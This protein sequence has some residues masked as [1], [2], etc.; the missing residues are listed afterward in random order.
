MYS[1]PI[2]LTGILGI[3]LFAV[4]WRALPA[5]APQGTSVL[6]ILE[7]PKALVLPVLCLGL[8]SIAAFSRYMRSSTIENLVQDYVRLARAKGAGPA[9]IMYRHVAR[10]AL[11]PVTTQ[12]GLFL[13]ILFAGT[14]ITEAVFNYP[15]MGLLFWTAAGARDYPTELG[16]VLVVGVATVV[17]SLLADI[18]YG[19]LD[20]R[21]R[22]ASRASQ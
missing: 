3:W 2:F 17:G 19:V 21:I 1:A 15:G 6:Q 13:P 8:G 16:V 7:D 5:Q 12:V 11:G 22:E 9:R 20:P 4:R 14:V 10:N 18:A